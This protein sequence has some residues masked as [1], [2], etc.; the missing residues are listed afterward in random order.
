MLP[1]NCIMAYDR[2]LGIKSLL[3]GFSGKLEKRIIEHMAWR[4]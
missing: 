3:G 2:P 4:F 1:T